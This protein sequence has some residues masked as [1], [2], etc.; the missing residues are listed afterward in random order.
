MGRAAV[1]VA[2]VAAVVMSTA[3]DAQGR[4]AD[5]LAVERAVLLPDRRLIT[6]DVQCRTT[7]ARCA[8]TLRAMTD[9]RLPVTAR[10]R[11]ALAPG[12]TRRVAL[13]LRGNALRR[14]AASGPGGVGTLVLTDRRG[15]T[16]TGAFELD[17][18]PTC[19]TGTTLAET[20]SVRVF[21][22][23]GFG[24]YACS[25]PTRG[26]ALMAEE[27][28]SLQMIAVE[29]VRIAWP[30]VAFTQEIAWKCSESRVD[31]FDLRARRVV[32]ERA[33]GTFA[34]GPEVDCRSSSA[35][36]ELVVRPW[37]A[38][39][40]SEAAGYDG[41]AA[42][43]AVDDG[44]G[45]TLDVGPDVD[46]ASLRLSADSQVSWTRAGQMQTAPLW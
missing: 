17:A 6:V 28:E 14:L 33:S 15:R 16:S 21:R 38:I 3:G 1:L 37:G 13:R 29:T 44:G 40:W 27:D 8:G 36:V 26:P 35:I 4:R 34:D 2:L 20:I 18:R 9:T 45:R 23:R 32:L 22:L 46:P 19:R 10:R 11:V 24:V 5:R 41:Q 43:R 31:V 7:R 42:V 30:F 25:G 12:R 39:A